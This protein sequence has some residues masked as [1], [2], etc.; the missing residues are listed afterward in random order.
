MGREEEPRVDAF[1]IG[2]TLVLTL[3]SL[4]L[5]AVC[6]RPEDHP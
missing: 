2:L 4:G 1:W 5:I 3:L 6:D